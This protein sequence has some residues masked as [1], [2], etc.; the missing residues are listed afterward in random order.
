MRFPLKP[1]WASAD[2]DGMDPAL[3]LPVLACVL[4]GAFGVGS[5]LYTLAHRL[6]WELEL[7]DLMVETRALRAAYEARKAA[8]RSGEVA[9]VNVDFVDEA[10]AE[11]A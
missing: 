8:M 10:P 9:E 6:S 5:A 7:H 11:A 1:A 2:P 3:V 4:V